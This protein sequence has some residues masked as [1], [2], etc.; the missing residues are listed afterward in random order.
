VLLRLSSAPPAATALVRA[1]AVL[2]DGASLAEAA[3]LADVA[4]E[5]AADI[6]DQLIALVIL[7]HGEGLEFAHPIVREAVY[8]DIGAL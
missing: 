4:E 5:K 3:G 6:A 7:K 1:V 2:G 8:A